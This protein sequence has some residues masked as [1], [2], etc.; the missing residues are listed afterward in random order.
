MKYMPLLIYAFVQGLE[1]FLHVKKRALVLLIALRQIFCLCRLKLKFLSRVIPSSST[2]SDDL[3]DFLSK[4][5]F[6]SMLL[7][8]KE[9]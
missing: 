6:F 3:M 7:Y 1:I 5:M 8:L 9:R 4:D 2:L